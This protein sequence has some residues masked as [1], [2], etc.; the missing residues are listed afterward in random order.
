MD[1]VVRPGGRR[2]TRAQR[3]EWRRRPS[4]SCASRP[5]GLGRSGCRTCRPSGAAWASGRRRWPPSRPKRPRSASGRSSSTPRRPTRATST[6]S[7]TGAPTTQKEKYLRPLCE[8]TARSCF[9]M[10]EPEV[11]GSRPHAHPDVR[12]PRRRRVGDQRAQVVHLRRPRREVRHPHRPHRGRPGDP[13]GGQ[14]RA[15]SSTCR[16]RAGRSSA[17]S[18]RCA[19]ATTTAR[20]ASTTC[21][22]PHANLLGGQGQGHLLGQYRLG[23]A[24]LA[25]CMRWI[26]QA[27]TALDMMVERSLERYSH[28]SLPRREAGHPVADRRLGHGAVPVQADGAARRVQDRA[29]ARLHRRGVDGQALRGQQPVAHHRPRHPGARRARL[30]HRHAARRTC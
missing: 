10:T 29:R 28:G 13:A 21:G 7:C 25:H 15:S 19:A 27:E 24:R 14:H 17:T 30:L 12:L 6:R 4:S 23:P 18:R 26:G 9:A 20:S 2:P 5:G 16:A 3:S 8:G 22:C 1:E 11:A